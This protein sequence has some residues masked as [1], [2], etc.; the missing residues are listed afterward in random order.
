MAQERFQLLLVASGF[1]RKALRPLIFRLKA[2]ATER[3]GGA[4]AAHLSRSGSTARRARG[5]SS[6]PVD[7]G[8]EDL[9]A[10]DHRAGDRA[11]ENSGDERLEPEP[12]RHR[13]DRADHD[14]PGADQHGG[15]VEPEP[16]AR[17]RGRDRR[18]GAGG[19][20]LLADG[21]GEGRADGRPGTERHRHRGWQAAAPQRAGLSLAGHQHQPRSAL[22]TDLGGLRRGHLADVEND[23]RV[24]EGHAGRRSQVPEACRHAEALCRQQRRARPDQDRRDRERADAPRVLPAAL[25]GRHRRRQGLRRSCPRTTRSTAPRAPSTSSC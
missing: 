16:R 13:V 22:G 6:P 7:A 20:Q 24:R 11:P 17:R 1:S 21:P 25:Q 19:Q 12:A 5:R 9:P 23:G 3:A 14:V 2:E 10:R 8:R 15:D 4:A 18:R